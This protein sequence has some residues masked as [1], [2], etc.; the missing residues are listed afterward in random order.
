MKKAHGKRIYCNSLDHTVNSTKMHF[1]ATKMPCLFQSNMDR[2]FPYR[3]V[4]INKEQPHLKWSQRPE[5]RALTQYHLV[6]NRKD[7]QLQTPTRR[8]INRK[9]LSVT[10]LNRKDVY[11]ISFRKLNTPAT[12]PVRT[13]SL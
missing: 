3:H 7:S 4:K 2:D 8:V 13:F 10:S 6:N 1:F 5:G 12:K 11:C 9:E